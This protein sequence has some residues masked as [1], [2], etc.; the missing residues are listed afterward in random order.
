M[1]TSGP[2]WK[3]AT[4]MFK[5]HFTSTATRHGFQQFKKD[6][7]IYP[8]HVGD[9]CMTRVKL[10]ASSHSRLFYPRIGIHVLDTFNRQYRS[11]C[12]ADDTYFVLMRGTPRELS[13]AFDLES[14]LDWEHR[15][16]QLEVF[17]SFTAS[18]CE[19]CRTRSGLREL[20]ANSQILLMSPLSAEMDRLDALDA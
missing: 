2:N 1:S 13:E 4:R 18:F 8:Q 11:G 6:I 3:A 20:A 17:W 19:Q 15:C 14:D 7:W 9:Q 5:D 12:E 16:E 10:Q